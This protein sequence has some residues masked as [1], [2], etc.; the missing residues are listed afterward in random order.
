VQL[1]AEPKCF[2]RYI[3]YVGSPVPEA[4]EYL[5]AAFNTAASLLHK[6]AEEPYYKSHLKRKL[7]G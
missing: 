2:K 5:A 3:V 6:E 1:T 7:P 4:A